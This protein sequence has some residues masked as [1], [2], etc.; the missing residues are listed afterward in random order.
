MKSIEISVKDE[1]KHQNI[2][3]DILYHADSIEDNIVIG[4][5]LASI[6]QIDYRYEPIKNASDDNTKTFLFGTFAGYKI[7]MDPTIPWMDWHVY[8]T[9]S[10]ENYIKEKN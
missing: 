10:I 9:D 8:Y 4:A 7:Y 6:L 5:K 2:I 1:T 3:C